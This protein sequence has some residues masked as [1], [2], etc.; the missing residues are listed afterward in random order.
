MPEVF[1]KYLNKIE[2][3]KKNCPPGLPGIIAGLETPRE[4]DQ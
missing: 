1:I 2:F 4:L 3:T